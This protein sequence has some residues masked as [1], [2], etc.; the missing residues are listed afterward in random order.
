[1]AALSNMYLYQYFKT[2]SNVFHWEPN[3]IK[4]RKRTLL[5][6]IAHRKDVY[7]VKDLPLIDEVRSY[8]CVQ[9]FRIVDWQDNFDIWFV[10][11]LQENPTGVLNYC[12]TPTAKV[13]NILHISILTSYMELKSFT[14]YTTSTFSFSRIP[15]FLFR[16]RNY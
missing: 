3:R 11:I 10:L 6:S 5:T 9:K 16:R 1:M 14:N 2:L 15:N 13:Q 12:F 7:I 8:F 4:L